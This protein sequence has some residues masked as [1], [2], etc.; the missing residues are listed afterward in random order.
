MPF[1]QSS[2]ETIPW[3]ALSHHLGRDLLDKPILSL[4]VADMVD[5]IALNAQSLDEGDEIRL[6]E[7]IARGQAVN[8]GVDKEKFW[9]RVEENL[10]P[11]LTRRMHLWQRRIRISLVLGWDCL[12]GIQRE[13]GEGEMLHQS[14]IRLMKV[15]RTD[16]PVGKAVQSL[17]VF[18]S[19]TDL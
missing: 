2:K 4:V 9:R 8:L 5:L 1:R 17:H 11:S 12:E 14:Q 16:V 10:V 7:E 18:T 6:G 19:F 15:R 3:L 13:R